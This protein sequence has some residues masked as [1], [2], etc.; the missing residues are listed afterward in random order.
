MSAAVVVAIVVA[1][2]QAQA[3]P[4]RAMADAAAEVVGDLGGVRVVERLPPSDE[5]ALRAE[6][7]L[8]ARA[9]VTL[10]WGDADR[11]LA[12]LRLHAARTDRWIER[13]LVFGAADTPEERGRAL[14]FALASMLPEGDPSLPR[15]ASEPTPLEPPPR[16]LG[17][18]A[19][20]AAF[21]AGAGLD[22]PAGGLG[23]RIAFERAL[24]PRLGAGLSLASRLGRATP[25]DARE[26][27]TTVGLGLSLGLLE[28]GRVG[29]AI[30]VEA[31]AVHEAV[32]RVTAQ[33]T[34]WRSHLMP[35]AGLVV[36]ATL[37]LAGPLAL[38]IA[39]G[40]ELAL[41]T[42]DV[43]VL[44]PGQATQARIPAARVVGTAGLQIRF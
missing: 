36:E 34:S 35:G 44:A 43:E 7:E 10:A 27:T 6:R 14:G 18:N 20:E 25:V 8:G 32:E 23:G 42:V 38:A 15:A 11:L 1:A 29:L 24:T 39:G 30:R 40:G 41:G 2:G 21:L 16:P 37:R 5:E 31:L 12:R 33:A 26:L 22:G 19:L 3:P 17:P 9:V 13:E 28:P 4:T